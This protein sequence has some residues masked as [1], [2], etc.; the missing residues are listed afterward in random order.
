MVVLV[1]IVLVV[2]EGVVDMVVPM[3]GGGETLKAW[4]AHVAAE[5]GKTVH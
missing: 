4:V 3:D 5:N 1:I 2:D